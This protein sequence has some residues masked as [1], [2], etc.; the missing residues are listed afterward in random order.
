MYI[1]HC[2]IKYLLYCTKHKKREALMT[3]LDIILVYRG[4]LFYKINLVAV[5]NFKI[6]TNNHITFLA[7]DIPECKLH[8]YLAAQYTVIDYWRWWDEEVDAHCSGNSKRTSIVPNHFP[9][10]LIYRSANWVEQGG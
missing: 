4:L 6:K 10:I 1:F 3:S 2:K 8:A 9:W 7:I 5:F